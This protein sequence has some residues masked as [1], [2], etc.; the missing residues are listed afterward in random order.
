MAPEVIEA[1]DG[2]V[3]QKA[4][5]GLRVSRSAAAELLLRRALGMQQGELK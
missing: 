3:A 1:L 2:V 5:E 4:A